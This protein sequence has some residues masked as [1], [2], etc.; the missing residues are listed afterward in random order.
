MK[1]DSNAT[2]LGCTQGAVLHRQSSGAAYLRTP[3]RNAGQTTIYHPVP[4]TE[5]NKSRETTNRCTLK[6]GRIY[7]QNLHDQEKLAMT[8][9]EIEVHLYVRARARFAVDEGT[10]LL[11]KPIRSTIVS[12]EDR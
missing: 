4:A 10:G 7:E 11:N 12:R 5:R 8:I 1:F 2:N 6:T 9:T 3:D